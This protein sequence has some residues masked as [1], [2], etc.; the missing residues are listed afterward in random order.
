MTVERGRA[1]D[2]GMRDWWEWYWWEWFEGLDEL[3][4]LGRGCGRL[5]V[6]LGNCGPFALEWDIVI[7]ERNLPY[8]RAPTEHA[9]MP[10]DPSL[11][12]QPRTLTISICSRA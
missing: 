12:A 5:G 8:T 10:H 11:G 7:L 4:R 9:P 3:A 6:G 1:G 2:V